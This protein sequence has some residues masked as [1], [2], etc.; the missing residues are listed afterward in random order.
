GGMPLGQGGHV[1][2][3]GA[4]V[5]LDAHGAPPRRGRL[6]ELVEHLAQEIDRDRDG[7]GTEIALYAEGRDGGFPRAFETRVGAL[8]LGRLAGL[9]R[10]RDVDLLDVALELATFGR[11]RFGGLDD[12]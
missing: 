3:E 6:I 8:L 4:A 5:A 2:R 1:G 10:E 12:A 7:L 11:R 9:G